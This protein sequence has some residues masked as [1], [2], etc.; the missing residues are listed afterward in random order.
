MPS[1][2]KF[3][4]PKDLVPQI[5]EMLSVAKNTGK[6]KKGVNETTKSIERRNAQF[7]VIAE[8]VQPEEIVV[9]L[10][11]LCDDNGIPFAYVPEK[12]ALGQAVGIAVGASA[13]AVENAGAASET[14]QDII[15]RLPKH[16]GATAASTPTPAAS[17]TS[18]ET[19]QQAAELKKEKVTQQKAAKK[20]KTGEKK[21]G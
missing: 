11:M 3:E 12:K 13:V 2:V 14:L 7:V 19:K 6:I 21:E 16:G 17:T 18:A 15:K 5:L 10:P 4:T 1:Y 9:H 20:P 8:D